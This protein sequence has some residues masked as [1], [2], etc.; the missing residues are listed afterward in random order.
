MNEPFPEREVTIAENLSVFVSGSTPDTIPLEIQECAKYLILDAI[1]VA[2]AASTYEFS[3]KTFGA[4]HAAFG[5]S[6]I[7]VIGFSKRLTVRDAV[8]MNGALIHAVD[9]DD[10]YT[11]GYLHASASAFPPHQPLSGHRW[12]SFGRR[13]VSR[14][15]A[16][17]RCRNCANCSRV[18]Y[19]FRGHFCKFD[20]AALSAGWIEIGY[21]A[22]CV[23]NPRHFVEQRHALRLQLR[24]RF[25]YIL[26]F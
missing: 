10:T 22:A 8:L 3:V 16:T 26:Y 1:G 4:L 14:T 24:K 6:D 12:Y 17:L 9:F 21:A 15:T 18:T 13:S 5:D 2:Y 23:P 19:G 11:P 25:V 20:D 7:E